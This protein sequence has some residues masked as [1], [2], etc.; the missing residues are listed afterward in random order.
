MNVK[1][2]QKSQSNNGFTLVELIVV[3]VI[4]S[5]LAAILV[6][7]FMGYIDQAKKSQCDLEKHSAQ[8]AVQSL[9]AQAYA[10]SKTID[11]VKSLDQYLDANIASLCE[12][13]TP[14][15]NDLHYAGMCPQ[16]GELYLDDLTFGGRNFTFTMY[17]TLHDGDNTSVT[18]TPAMAR[19]EASNAIL[20]TELLHNEAYDKSKFDFSLGKAIVSNKPS[21]L[22]KY[23]EDADYD[24]C[25]FITNDS[26]MGNY[27]TKILSAYGISASVS[28]TK[29][30][31]VT[32]DGKKLTDLKKGDTVEVIQY[33]YYKTKE[34]GQELQRCF[35]TRVTTATVNNVYPE[36][37]NGSLNFDRSDADSGSS[38][39]LQ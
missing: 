8:M 29:I 39:T 15:A 1:T 12:G 32:V 33:L 4:L 17:C 6:P 34:N 27:A 14:G 28:Y 21:T 30:V 16:G 25:G 11:D 9:Y 20:R 37:Y 5:I 10:R 19:Q 13:A 22:N 36:T 38:W 18:V 24:G 31:S 23:L 2:H 3:M 35:A 26:N 7:A